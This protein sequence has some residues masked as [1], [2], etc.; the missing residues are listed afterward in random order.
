[1]S[2][3]IHKGQVSFVNHEKKYI[4]IEYEENGRKKTVNG[5]VDD[6]QQQK[7]IDKKLIKKKHL[8]HIGDTV[9]FSAG[10]SDRGDRMVASN[11][12]FL[13]NTALDVLINKA[14]TENN[15][16]GYLKVIDGKYFVKEIDSY[17][18]FPVPLSPWQL[19][20]TEA[21]LN[22][23][24]TFALENMDNKEKITAKLYNNKYIPQFYTAVKLNKANTPVEATVY[25][26]SPHGIY[27]NLIEDKI[28]VKLPFKEGVKINDKIFVKI[29]YLSPSKI[30]AEAL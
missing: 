2:N 4:I 29:V 1:M 28:Q 6:K 3:T 25:K 16:I 27:L 13:Y 26:V 8:F 22:E 7:W 17:L 12:Q 5:P 9:N 10:L 19:K 24:V 18:F 15:F 30:I 20:P 11:I 23:A 21:E 14:K